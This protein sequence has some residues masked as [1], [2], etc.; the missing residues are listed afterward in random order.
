[1]SFWIVS[2][3][4]SL[5][6]IGLILRAVLRGGHGAD[7]ASAYDVEIYRDQLKEV[8]RD[9]A[10]GV[11]SPD[12]AEH[13]RTEISRRILA[14]DRATHGDLE[15]SEKSAAKVAAILATLAAIGGAGLLYANLGAPGYTDIPLKA[16]I[17][18]SDEMRTQRM[19]QQE[20]AR[21]M[22]DIPRV[23]PP[24][25]SAEF[26]DLMVKLRE[27][28]KERPDDLQGLALLARNEA[29]LGR[30][31][32]AATAQ[33]RIIELKG[34]ATTAAD[35]AFHADVLITA[36]GGYVSQEAEASL[37]AALEKNPDHPISRYYLAQYML[38]VDRPDT[39]FRVMDKLLRESTPDAPW[40]PSLRAQIEDVAWRAGV[41]YELPSLVR[42]GGPTAED[43]ANADG[44]AAEDRQAMIEGM[45]A[46]LSERLSSEGGSAEEWAQLI[47]ALGVLDRFDEARS[48]FV[49]SLRVFEGR[50]DALELMRAAGR[51]VGISED[52]L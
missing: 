28:V 12:E 40:V 4:I 43:I 42:T 35:Y 38:Q 52:D 45:V 17:A 23:D 47:R 5:A 26:L 14:A 36:A 7:T 32:E 46:Q 49:E 19:T 44:M 16:R 30:A 11:L 37:R 48:I 15:R 33:G 25:A 13:T 21:V 1:M 50:E 9:L 39:A 27:T 6:V 51:T 3:L 31:A 24:E 41:S 8:E 20:A 22:A 29:S 10:R 18:A 34:D 2:V